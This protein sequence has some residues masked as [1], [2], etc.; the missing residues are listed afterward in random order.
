MAASKFSDSSKV[1]PRPPVGGD[2]QS[3]EEGAKFARS[4]LSKL[5]ENPESV[6]LHG[7]IS[8]AGDFQA[9]NKFSHGFADTIQEALAAKSD[10]G[11]TTEDEEADDRLIEDAAEDLEA[12]ILALRALAAL[13]K[14][15]DSHQSLAEHTLII[16]EQMC[17]DLADRLDQHALVFATRGLGKRLREREKGAAEGEPS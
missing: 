16:C 5:R 15:T 10:A 9:R 12:S 6:D 13:A 2:A 8:D 3:R 14:E 1:E 11:A 4:Y 17:A 7:Y